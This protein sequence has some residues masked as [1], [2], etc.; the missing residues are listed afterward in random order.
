[1]VTLRFDRWLTVCG[2]CFRSTISSGEIS[3]Y[4]RNNIIMRF[5]FQTGVAAAVVFLAFAGASVRAE[6]SYRRTV[7]VATRAVPLARAVP[8]SKIDPRS[9]QYVR[10]IV[11]A[12]KVIA[13]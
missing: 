2:T 5:C 13:S 1:M 3:G 12:P 10:T 6:N 7:T 11:V 8:V 4:N 9:G